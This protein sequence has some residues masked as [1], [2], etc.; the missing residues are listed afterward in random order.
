VNASTDALRVQRVDE[1]LALAATRVGPDQARSIAPFAREQFRQI[2]PDE[3]A[4]RPVQDLLGG[5]LSH[6]QFGAVR[7]PGRPKVRVFSPSVGEHGWGSR[8]SVIEIVNDDMP[9]LVDTA[10]MEI[11]RQGLTLHLIVHPIYAVERD[12]KGQLQAIQDSRAASGASLRAWMA[13]SWPL[14]SRST[15]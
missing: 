7:E 9:F 6:W 1:V 3:L 14:A 11:N 8:H 13:C 5:L 10:T 12:A 2:D 4:E 15:A